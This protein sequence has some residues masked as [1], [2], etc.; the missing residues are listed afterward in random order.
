[1]LE[2]LIN[3]LLIGFFAGIIFSIPVAGPINVL[4]MS[5]ALS[6][7]L[8]YC[9]RTAMGASVIEFFYVLIIVFG[10]ASLFQFYEPF[11]P[12]LLIVGSIVL[13]IVGVR[14]AKTDLSNTNI[15]DKTLLDDKDKNRG[16]FRTGILINLTNPSLF[17][18]W[19]TSS[20]LVFSFASSIGIN[21]GGLDL[22]VNRNV[23]SFKEI[24]ST[25]FED[26]NDIS[27]EHD[28]GESDN[29]GSA[30][31]PLLLSLVYATAVAFGSY[32]YLYYYAKFIVKHRLKININIINKVVRGLGG[33]LILLSVYL[34]Y[35]GFDILL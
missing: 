18:G 17:I 25:Q 31:H 2:S 24:T 4:I 13:L 9:I 12:Y 19:L 10:I 11:I 29:G 32:V 34:A 16:G 33:V 8:R 26:F 30:A 22:L 20:F 7:R 27:D 6:G 1:M 15:K 14:I 5:N 35:K 3:V 28:E 23:N 21:T